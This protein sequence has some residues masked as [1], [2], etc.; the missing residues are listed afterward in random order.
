MNQT[1]SKTVI[2]NEQSESHLLYKD[3]ETRVVY[4]GYY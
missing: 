4:Y 2:N 3:L 1:T